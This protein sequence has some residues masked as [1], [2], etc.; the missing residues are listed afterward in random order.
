MEATILAAEGRWPS[1]RPTWSGPRRRAAS[2]RRR[3]V[4]LSTRPGTRSSGCTPGGRN[5]K[6]AAAAD[7]RAIGRIPRSAFDI[8]ERVEAVSRAIDA[9]V[10]DGRQGVGNGRRRSR[11]RGRDPLAF[12]PPPSPPHGGTSHAGR[13]AGP[14]RPVRLADGVVPRRGPTPAAVRDHAGGGRRAGGRRRRVAR[15]RHAG[16]VVA[17][18]D[19]H[20]GIGVRGC[21]V[22]RPRRGGRHVRDRRHRGGRRA[23]RPPPS[24]RPSRF[25]LAIRRPHRS[26][27]PKAGGLR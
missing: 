20:D 12:V 16:G 10:A 2:R 7:R 9:E 19:S 4:R 15:G 18:L 1:G 11:G 6:P 24:E 5:S 22:D 27:P 23:P 21:P 8:G 13:G 14:S 3:R 26:D 17:A 25:F